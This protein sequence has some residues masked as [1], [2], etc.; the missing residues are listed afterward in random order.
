M[1]EFKPPPIELDMKSAD[2]VKKRLENSLKCL[3]FSTPAA[4]QCFQGECQAYA[5]VLGSAGFEV[6]ID[7]II[8]EKEKKLEDGI[9]SNKTEEPSN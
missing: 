4:A 5:A 2:A 7:I 9:P 8:T 1:D 6:D 3:M